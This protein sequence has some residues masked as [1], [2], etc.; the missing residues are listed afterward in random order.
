[1]GYRLYVV[2][3]FQNNVISRIFGDF[4]SGVLHRT[5]LNDL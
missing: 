1:M 5:T 3:S 4:S 2:A